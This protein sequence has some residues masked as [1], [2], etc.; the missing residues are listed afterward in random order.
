MQGQMKI[1]HVGSHQFRESLR[2]LLRELWFS[3]CSSRETPFREWDFSFRELFFELREL[4][5]EYPGTPGQSS[6]RMAFSL[7]E[8]FSWNWGGPQASELTIRSKCA[9]RSDSLYRE[10]S[11]SLHFHYSDLPCSSSSQSLCVVNSLRFH[12]RTLRN[13]T[14]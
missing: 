9:S 13:R 4:L 12:S 7:R 3:H 8:R 1:F 11:E 10:C 5:R 6:A 14:P 2:E